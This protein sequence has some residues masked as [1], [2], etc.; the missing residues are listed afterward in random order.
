METKRKTMIDT[1]GEDIAESDLETAGETWTC[2]RCR[3][4]YPTVSTRFQNSVKN[5]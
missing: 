2:S 3:V 5:H 1:G 4:I